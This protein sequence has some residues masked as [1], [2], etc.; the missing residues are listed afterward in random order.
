MNLDHPNF[1]QQ[2]RLSRVAARLRTFT[3]SELTRLAGVGENTIYSF[4]SKLAQLPQNYLQGENLPTSKRGRPHRRYTL[5]EAGVDYLLQRN[6]RIASI[7]GAESASAAGSVGLPLIAPEE[8]PR[9]NI[10]NK[11]APITRSITITDTEIQ[12]ESR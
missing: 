6:A 3:V 9:M 1:G 5:T 11:P 2:Y 7:L 8:L 10:G 4:I 12:K